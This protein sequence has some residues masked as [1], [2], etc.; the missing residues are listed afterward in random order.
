MAYKN[1]RLVICDRCG[2]TTFC[3]CSGEGEADGGYT[4]WNTFNPTPEGWGICSEIK[5][6]FN[7]CPKCNAEYTKILNNFK[8][9]GFVKKSTEA[10]NG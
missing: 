4:R 8:T 7:L 2:D 10:F 5:D 1:G 3:E 9:K 6:I